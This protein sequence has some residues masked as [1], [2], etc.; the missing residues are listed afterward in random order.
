MKP[1]PRISAPFRFLLLSVA[2]IAA[3]LAQP[4]PAVAG[5]VELATVPMATSTTTTVK[6]NLMYVLDDSGSMAW[7][8]M[9]DNAKNFAGK[10][11]YNSAQCNG[12]YYNPNI[13]YSPPVDSTGAPLNATA[14]TFSAA[15]KDGYNTS[16]GTTD[17]STGF[18]GGSGS[19]S[20]GISLTAGP[21]FYYTYT[22]SQTTEALKNY[23]NSSSTFYTECNS[24]IGSTPGSGVFTLTRLA[25]VPTTTITISASGGAG[26]TIKVTYAGTRSNPSKVSSVKV[27][28]ADNTIVEILK[29]ATNS[30]RTVSTLASYIAAQIQACFGVTLPN[31]NCGSNAYSATNVTG[32]DTVSISGPSTAAGATIP[33]PVSGGAGVTITNSGTVTTTAF[34]AA[35]TN[36]V[37]SITVGGTELLS[38]GA[39]GTSRGALATDIA[40]KITATG[41]SA[42]ASGNIVTITGPSSASTLTPVIT[43]TAGTMTFATA[44]FPE[45]TP[46]KLQNFANWY[47]YYSHRMLMMKTGSGLA[48]NN[49]TDKY[50]V[51]FITMNNN[52]SPGIVEVDTFNAGQRSKW[53]AKLY[54]SQANNTTPLREILSRVGQYYAHKFGNV[55]TYKS[56]ITVGNGGSSNS[57]SVGSITVNGVELMDNDSLADTSTSVVAANIANQINAPQVTDFGASSSGSVITIFGPANAGG[58]AT[59]GVSPVVQNDGGGMTFT[60]TPFAATTVSSTLNGI[61]PADPIQYSCQQ[62]FTI[63]ST[64]GYWNGSTTYNLTGSTVGQVDGSAPRPYND[65]YQA[66]TKTTTT[67]TQNQYSSSSSGLG[68]DSQCG[69]VSGS[70]GPRKQRLLVQPQI[71]SCAVTTVAGVDGAAVCTSWSNNGSQAYVSPYGSATSTCTDTVTLPAPNPSTPVVKASPPTNPVTVSGAA[72]GVSDTLSD[73]A[74]YYYQTDLRDNNLGNCTGALGTSVCEN[75]VFQSG[76]DNNL[77]Q[78]M[79]TFTLG[80]GARGRMV[81]SSSYLTDT[82][83]DFVAVKLASTASG[84]V[85]PWQNND[86]TPCNWPT[87]SSGAVENIDDLWHAAINGRGAFFSATDPQTLANGLAN[88]LTSINSK[89]GAAAAAATSTLNPVAGNNQAFVASYTTLSWEGNL[90]A[91]GINTET[92]VVNENANWCVENVQAASCQ[93]PGTVVADSSGDTTAYF[94]VTANSVVCPGGELVGTDCRVPVAT[95][96]TGTMNSKVDLASD[97]RTIYTANKNT[98]G[99]SPPANGTVLVP[100][101]TAYRAANPGY[102]DAT[103]LAGLSQWPP[104]SDTSANA[105]A[106]R[107]NAPDDNLL[108]YLRGQHGHEYDRS[109]VTVINQFYRNRESV[110]GDALESQPAFMGA[111]IFSYP[112]PGYAEFLTAQASR[113]GTVYMGTNDGMM[114]A[115]NADTGVERWAYIPSMVVGNMWK[116]ADKQYRD[117]HTN[118]VNGSPVTTDVC[119]ARCDQAYTAG[120]PSTSP[121]WK[122]ILVAGLNGG[123]RGYF[124]LDITDPANPA[125]MWEFTTSSGIGA[126]TDDDL[127]YTFGQ[128]VVTRLAGGT[129]VVLVTSGYDNGTDSAATASGSFIANSP[130]GSGEGYLYVLNAATG[131]KISKISTGAGSPSAPSG[132]AKIAGYNVESGGNKVSYVYGGDLLGN[133]WRFDVNAT[134]AANLGTNNYGNGSVLKFATLFSDTAATSPQPIMTTPILG[135]IVGKRVIFI[136][137]G[138]YLETADLSNVQTQSQYAIKD[139]DA[140][141]TY[142]NPRTSLVQQYLINNPDGTATRLSAATPTA[143]TTGSNAV[144]FGIGRGW[145]LDFPTSKERVNIDAR[146]VLGTLVVPTIVPS[147]TDCSPGGSGWLN[148]FDYKT[149]GPVNATPGISGVKYDSTIV[150]VNVL[151]IGGNPVVEVV[152]STDPTPKKDPNVEFKAA[153][154]GFAGK[155]VLWRELIP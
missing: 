25:A 80:L 40:S 131:Q 74:M 114:H 140:T 95:A 46:D 71:R 132:L 81:Y 72:G 38:S 51:G 108:S 97:T 153:A 4:L 105:D 3:G 66:S 24:S 152:T 64:D 48:F 127:G 13:T 106:F 113:A 5:P 98:A 77:Q 21:A 57:T 18:K 134:T 22:G 52:V 96:C 125:L 73:V 88:A 6:P 19:G 99:A 148:F 62:N 119:T 15:Y 47:S 30:S 49:V 103:L 142:V 150:G 126:V 93:S 121:V 112:Y 50:R 138:K 37:S 83:G 139:D 136:G 137:T 35:E 28:L 11:G 109:S 70:S 53:F 32:S 89:V 29:A 111:P 60:V 45:S 79:T 68:S 94:C 86:G 9:P 91:R 43:Q 117:K 116:L 92:G 65:G 75:N 133:L 84:G 27:K 146:L 151:F 120:S 145:F 107:A 41:Y 87:P 118:Y 58:S 59:T 12:V 34:P 129:W 85:C 115:F 123:G 67:Y 8:Y 101:D 16:S 33:F 78:H 102:F 44:A 69:R 42:V 147:S 14:T 2:L 110:M 7:D 122:T 26:A 135:T 104:L 124:A 144:D 100:F 56:T 54:G 141:A 143:T 39:T 55:T 130:A 1:D 90:E 61:S 82:T 17:L 76:S 149:G 155:R 23:F 36:T 154:A 10:Y 31:G 63:L 128:P 20:S